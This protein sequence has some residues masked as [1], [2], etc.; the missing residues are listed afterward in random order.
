MSQSGLVRGSRGKL[1]HSENWSSPSRVW[2]E[3][4]KKAGLFRDWVHAL[5]TSF[6][7]ANKKKKDLKNRENGRASIFGSEWQDEICDNI[8]SQPR[9]IWHSIVGKESSDPF[10][11]LEWEGRKGEKLHSQM[12]EGKIEIVRLKARGRRTEGQNELGWIF[13]RSF[14]WNPCFLARSPGIPGL[15]P[16]TVRTEDMNMSMV[17][18]L[19]VIH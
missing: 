3:R 17:G 7:P 15:P 13:Y 16:N 9:W 10:P 6:N 8:S 1:S 11:S 4:G 12:T 14:G 2:G 18:Y 19:P 5:N